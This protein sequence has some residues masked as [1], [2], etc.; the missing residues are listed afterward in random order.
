MHVAWRRWKGHEVQRQLAGV[1]EEHL[2]KK[3]FNRRACVVQRVVA[4]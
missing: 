1:V 2:L 3:D 4:T